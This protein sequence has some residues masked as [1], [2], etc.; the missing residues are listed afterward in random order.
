[1][2]ATCPE[3]LAAWSFRF[4]IGDEAKT[5]VVSEEADRDANDCFSGEQATF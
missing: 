3:H 4:E 2:R 5:T 1:M